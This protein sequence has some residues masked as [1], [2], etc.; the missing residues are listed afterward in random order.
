[1]AKKDENKNLKKANIKTEKKAVKNSRNLAD[2]ILEKKMNKKPTKS[3]A[4]GSVKNPVKSSA[5]KSEKISEMSSAKGEKNPSV[6]ASKKPTVTG[7]RVPPKEFDK[8]WYYRNSVQSPDTDVKFF[9]KLYRDARG[10]DAETFREDFCGTF[11]LSCEWVKLDKN[12]R[13]IGL[14]LDPEPINYGK[15]NYL[16]DLDSEQQRRVSILQKNVLDPD[17]PK[18]DIIGAQNFSYFIFKDRRLMLRYFDNC[19]QSLKNDGLF[20][21][22]CF[23]GS[24]CYE[25]I[26]EETQHKHFSYYWDQTSFDPVTNCALFYIH[27]KPKYKKK[28][29]K[30]FTYDWRMWSIPEL[31]E[32]LLEAGF[33]DSFVYWEGTTKDGEGDGVF[34]K[35]K[36]GEACQAWIAYIVGVR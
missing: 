32:I 35:R 23:G 10:K 27:Y 19:R 29:E 5:K 13:A 3:V 22:D 9:K 15:Q 20:I 21:M 11:S 2:N 24:Q 16:P 36:T 1:M 18:A 33:R 34:K 14:D 31:Q 8:Y 6:V 17:L 25:P 26:E 7:L 4:E 28:I 12:N 30:V